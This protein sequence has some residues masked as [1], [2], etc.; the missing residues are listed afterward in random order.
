M[1]ASR[2]G[3]KIVFEAAAIVLVIAIYWFPSIKARAQLRPTALPPM[4]APDLS[5]YLNLSQITAIDGSRVMN[6]YYRIPVPTAGAGYLK[7]RLAPRLFGGLNRLLD[8]RTWF[9]RL[10]W[11][12]F[13]WTLLC[14]VA[15]WLFDRFLPARSP[16]IVLFGFF[17]LMLFNFGVLKTLLLAWV[18]LPSLVG[19]TDLQLPFLCVPSFR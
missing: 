1:V 9:A 13:W 17:I 16:T 10:L 5:M 7:F 4:F 15:I 18:H 2:T 8:N 19:F 12:A 6:P 14:V 11:N 3:S